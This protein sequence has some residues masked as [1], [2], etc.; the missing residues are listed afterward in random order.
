MEIQQSAVGVREN[1][2]KNKDCSLGGSPFEVF[3]T[4][5]VILVTFLQVSGTGK[6]S[7]L[8][9]HTLSFGVFMVVVESAATYHTHQTSQ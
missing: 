1:H 5:S 7:V 9:K 3:T 6:S 8:E 2:F 4:A